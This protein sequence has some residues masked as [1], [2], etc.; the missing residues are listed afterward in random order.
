M[1][2]IIV[3]ILGILLASCGEREGHF[4]DNGDTVVVDLKRND[5]IGKTTLK[6]KILPGESLVP[7][8]A[9]NSLILDDQDIANLYKFDGAISIQGDAVRVM[10][11]LS[12]RDGT[13]VRINS[14]TT[15]E[16]QGPGLLD[17]LLGD[18]SSKEVDVTHTDE[19]YSEPFEMNGDFRI[20][21]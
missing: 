2:H 15:K 21:K 17:M 9:L 7:G 13:P 8:K 19:I 3:I 12:R 16:R 6:F 20:M 10:L 5:V 11:T 14:Y 4:R 18:F 1:K